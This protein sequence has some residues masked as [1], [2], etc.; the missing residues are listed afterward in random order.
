MKRTL[1]LRNETK[2]FEE[3]VA[4]TPSHASKLVELGHRIVVEENPDSVFPIE[5]YQSVGCEIAKKN[6]WIT[7][8]PLEATILGLK[9][10]EDSDIELKRRHI[11]FAH[12]FKNQ[13][14][15]KQILERYKN[16]GGKLFDLEYLVDSNMKRVA[17]FGHWAGYAGAA[18]GLDIWL[19]EVFGLNYNKVTKL[20]SFSSKE[21]LLTKV[22]NH[23]KDLDLENKK[24]RI[25]IIGAYG[26]SGQGAKSFIEE[27]G[28]NA[29]LWGSQD[30]IA[31]EYIKELLDFDIIINCAF[32]NKSVGKWL[33]LEML[34]GKQ[35]LK[36]LSDVSCD[37]YGPNNP[38]PIYH[39]ATTMDSPALKILGKGLTV[40]AIDHLPS[41]LPRESSVDFGDQLFPHLVDYMEGRL[42]NGPWER[43]LETFYKVLFQQTESEDEINLSDVQEVLQ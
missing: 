23:L 38:F 31:K 33:T 1:W 27:L 41:L 35:R 20:K 39:Q 34:N 32:I 28:L 4:L 15:S 37:P 2:P 14:G 24:P 42:A 19:H 5:E 18:L 7:E 36:V 9:E 30:T 6:S 22:Q 3:R 13:S 16:G 43:A 8:A 40:T 25:L 10:L 21:A 17:A 11:H 12:I 26:R 29:E